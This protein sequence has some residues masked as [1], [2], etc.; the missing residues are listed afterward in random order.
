MFRPHAPFV[1]ALDASTGP[2]RESELIRGVYVVALRAFEDDRGWFFE[3]FRRSWLPDIPEMIQG[4]VSFSRA[5]VLRGMHYHRRQADFWLVPSGHVRAALYDA[6]RSSPT[7]GATQV[8]ELGEAHPFGLYIPAGVAHG[9][10]ALTPSIMTYL[11][12]RY[13]D[14][15]DELGIRWDDP[16]LGID[17]HA[18]DP[19]VSA[20][21]QQNPRL[22]E[23]PAS[24]LPR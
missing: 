15:S 1:R 6:R 12:D 5:G 20:R 24:E 23:I 13:Y 3:S 14:N 8:L 7:R 22:A 19:I 11:V 9:F 4:N 10:H 21:D 2:A 17:W 18:R 16:A